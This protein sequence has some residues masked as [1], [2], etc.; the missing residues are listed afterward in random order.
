MFGRQNRRESGQSGISHPFSLRDPMPSSLPDTTTLYTDFVFLS[1]P[2][3]ILVSAKRILILLVFLTSVLTHFHFM[4]PSRTAQTSSHTD[5]WVAS[6]RA[7]RAGDVCNPILSLFFAAR[8]I[9]PEAKRSV[10]LRFV[11][12]YVPT[13]TWLRYANASRGLLFCSFFWPPIHFVS[14]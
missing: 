5:P 11:I 7:G 13:I 9:R 1:I 2:A 4:Y 6:D 12:L 10:S 14:S 8:F 3:C